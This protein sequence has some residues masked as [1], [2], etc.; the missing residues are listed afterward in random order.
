MVPTETGAMYF[1][2]ITKD[3]CP[4]TFVRTKLAIEGLPPGGI[5]EVRLAGTEPLGNLPRSLAELGHQVLA[6]TAEPG[7]VAASGAPVHRLRVAKSG[8]AGPA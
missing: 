6:I 4:L 2:D 7:A 3:V 8:A 1:L 5:L